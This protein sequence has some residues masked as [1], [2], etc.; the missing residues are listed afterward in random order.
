VLK[1]QN[2]KVWWETVYDWLDR[3]LTPANAWSPGQ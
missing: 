1:P 2:A 3:W